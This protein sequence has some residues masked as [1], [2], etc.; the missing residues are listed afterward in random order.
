MN[1][2]LSLSFT[3]WVDMA[4]ALEVEWWFHG[5]RSGM[6]I[7]KEMVE[8]KFPRNHHSIIHRLI[9][10]SKRELALE[11]VIPFLLIHVN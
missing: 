1:K 11:I 7:C 9:Q 6:P 4:L 5:L 2:I 8:W 10:A 3:L